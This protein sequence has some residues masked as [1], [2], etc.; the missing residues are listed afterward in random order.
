[1]SQAK[2]EALLSAVAAREAAVINTALGGGK[3]ADMVEASEALKGA[4]QDL[5]RAVYKGEVVLAPPVAA[6]MADP[7]LEAELFARI[8]ELEAEAVALV[9]NAD[10]A[11]ALA[12]AATARY[13]EAAL[14]AAEGRRALEES[15]A[16][17]ADRKREVAGLLEAAGHQVGLLAERRQELARLELELAEE[18]GREEPAVDRRAVSEFLRGYGR[19]PAASWLSKADNWEAEAGRAREAVAAVWVAAQSQPLDVQRELLRYAAARLRHL[20]GCAPTPGHTAQLKQWNLFVRTRCVADD[21]KCGF[22]HG[23]GRDQEPRS[24]G[25]WSDDAEYAL[26]ELLAFGVDDPNVVTQ[27]AGQ[28]RVEMWLDA[29]QDGTLTRNAL[30]DAV[31][32]AVQEGMALDQRVLGALATLPVSVWNTRS[33]KPVKSAVKRFLAAAQAEEDAEDPEVDGSPFK[34]RNILIVGGAARPAITK[35]LTGAYAANDAVWLPSGVPDDTVCSAIGRLGEGDLAFVLIRHVS[36]GLSHKAKRTETPGR[37]VY[38]IGG[39][40]PGALARA[41]GF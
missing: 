16:L 12:A 21:L 23:F 31:A 29:E 5:G 18:R 32:D 28:A 24:G 35:A 14:E 22:I 15:A 8:Q 4:L 20:G 1:M 30:R 10:N 41:A 27:G 7:S 25:S 38:V 40:G 33:A 37:V 39:Y 13:Q 3:R 11:S 36:H 34:G 19:I 6:P 9:A 17:E 2:F 26:S